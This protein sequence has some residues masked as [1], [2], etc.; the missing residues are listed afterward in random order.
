VIRS[1]SEA[2]ISSFGF[3]VSCLFN[4]SMPVFFA[5]FKSVLQCH[6]QLETELKVA[7]AW[8]CCYCCCVRL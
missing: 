5:F 1:R 8:R 6:C 2:L 3:G 7:E 4:S